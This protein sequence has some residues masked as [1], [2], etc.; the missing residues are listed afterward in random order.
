MILDDLV[1]ATRTRLARAEAT[2]PLAPLR[3]AALATPVPTG[4]PRFLEALD[5]HF[6]LIAELKQASPSKGVI[7]TAFPVAQIA[8]D[9]EAG[10]VDAMSVLTEPTYFHGSLA[11]LREVAGQTQVPLLRKDFILDDRM[12]LE[13]RAAGASLVLL[14]V[15]ILADGQLRE[16][17][18]TALKLGLVPLVECHNEDEIRRALVL[19]PQ[20][21]GVNNRDLR[22]FSVDFENSIRLR[23]MVPPTI[24]VI[25][26]SGITE[27]GQLTVLRRGGLDGALIGETFM[28]ATDRRATVQRYRAASEAAV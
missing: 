11:T 26:E 9:Y 4:G 1:A 6:G 13:A 23:A 5:A 28:R 7:A 8:A 14:I 25:A 16:L 18:T 20:L 15:G 24:K 3:E 17:Y 10:G 22:D 2:K 21:I 27:P 19:Q 12:L